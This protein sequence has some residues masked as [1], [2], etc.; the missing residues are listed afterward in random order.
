MN[1]SFDEYK[2]RTGE[3]NLIFDFYNTLM[4]KKKEKEM[5]L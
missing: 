2:S 1:K 3:E 5:P 4:L